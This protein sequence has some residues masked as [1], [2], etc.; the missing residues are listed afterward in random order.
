MT[1]NDTRKPTTVTF[2]SLN[3]GQCFID[4]EGCYCMVL[5]ED[6]CDECNAVDLESGKLYYFYADQE[7]VK[8]NARLEVF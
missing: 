2:G 4:E 6:A 8:V 3:A 7:V 1:I 5:E